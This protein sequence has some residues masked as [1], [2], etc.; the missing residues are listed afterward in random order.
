VKF[1]I[2][3]A[4]VGGGGGGGKPLLGQKKQ[5]KNFFLSSKKWEGKHFFCSFCFAIIK[6][7]LTKKN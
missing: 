2:N 4:R 6:K 5:K 7:I 1:A 3:L